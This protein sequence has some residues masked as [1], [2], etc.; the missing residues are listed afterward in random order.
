MILGAKWCFYYYAHLKEIKTRVFSWVSSKEVIGTV[1]NIG[2]A[3]KRPPHLH[4]SITTLFPYFWKA[5]KSQQGWRKMWF[6]NP[7]PYLNA[8]RN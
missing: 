2:N 4:Y 8:A 3:R 6:I 5:D 1:G 7:I